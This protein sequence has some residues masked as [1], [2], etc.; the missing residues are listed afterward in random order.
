MVMHARKLPRINDGYYERHQQGHSSYQNSKYSSSKSSY[1]DRYN[2]ERQ[3][4][5][6]NSPDGNTSRSN[7]PDRDQSPRN[8]SYGNKTWYLQKLHEKE[9]DRPYRSDQGRDRPNNFKDKYYSSDYSRSPKDRRPVNKES[10]YPTNHDRNNS[11][12]TSSISKSSNSAY[13]S[14][15]DSQ[16]KPT[17]SN[18]RDKRDERE[19][20][21]KVGDWSEHTS[22]SGKK[23]YYNCKTEVSQWEKPR[24]WL[25]KEGVMHLV[26][27]QGSS[28][29][30]S[31]SRLVQD[32]HS[33]V[34]SNSVM[35]N[36][37]SS[38]GN[39]H[40]KYSQHGRDRENSNSNW[41]NRDGASYNKDDHYSDHRLHENSSNIPVLGNESQAQDMEISSENS[42]PTSEH[43]T[44]AAVAQQ[45]QDVTHLSL[46]SSSGPGPPIGSIGSSKLSHPSRTEVKAEASSSFSSSLTPNST[47]IPSSNSKS[48]SENTLAAN[49]PK[50]D[51]NGA[52]DIGG[53]PTPTHSE[54]QDEPEQK[55]GGGSPETAGVSALQGISLQGFYPMQLPQL[56]PGLSQYVKDDLTEHVRGWPAENAEKQAHKLATEAHLITSMRITDISIALKSARSRVRL[57][58]IQSTLLEQRVM[59]Y[60]HEVKSLENMKTPTLFTSDDN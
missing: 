4:R 42:T 13:G 53:P 43:Y 9:R 39:D 41:N 45:Q 3:D 21:L 15:K 5:S 18:V 23:Y 17:H 11:D 52:C 51:P 24:E 1:P 29:S 37:R 33:S 12:K 34:R 56:T 20:F 47:P 50:T 2:Q 16:R 49:Q 48:L 7:T 44:P 19:R 26:R 25:E 55:P 35:N 60:R 31:S 27:S 28:S 8:R 59:L 32:K 57:N 10:G 30:S 22:S 40:A 54:N 36:Y 38:G 58:E 46:N 6:R 14:S